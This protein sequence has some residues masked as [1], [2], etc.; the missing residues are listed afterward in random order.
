M[1]LSLLPIL[2]RVLNKEVLRRAFTELALFPNAPTH[3]VLGEFGNTLDWDQPSGSPQ[4][5]RCQCANVEVGH[6]VGRIQNTC[7]IR[8]RRHRQPQRGFP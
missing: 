7:N 1:G 4:R 5:A 6:N 3:S 8:P 2:L